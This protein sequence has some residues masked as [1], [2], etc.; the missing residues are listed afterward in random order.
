[1]LACG[2]GLTIEHTR[3]GRMGGNFPLVIGHEITGEIT[4][5]GA[6]WRGFEKAR[7]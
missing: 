6:A 1:M 5:V 7:P 2:A 3:A 4:Q